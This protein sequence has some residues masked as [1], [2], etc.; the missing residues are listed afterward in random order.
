MENHV[1]Y[2]ETPTFLESQPERVQQFILGDQITRP[3]VVLTC[4]PRIVKIENCFYDEYKQL[5]LN[6]TNLKLKNK[7][8][9]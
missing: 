6:N 7:C 8:R 3:G 9:S 4:P 2:Y 1:I 5:V